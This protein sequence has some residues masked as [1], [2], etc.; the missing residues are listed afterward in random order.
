VLWVVAADHH[1]GQEIAERRA[2][3]TRR[4]GAA[5]VLLEAHPRGLPR[6]VGDTQG[7]WATRSEHQS[8]AHTAPAPRVHVH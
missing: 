6:S 7:Y 2:L 1:Q 4:Q 3:L 5:A 8:G